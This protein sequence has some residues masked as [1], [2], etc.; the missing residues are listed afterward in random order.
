M[1][2]MAVKKTA[3]PKR[4]KIQGKHV[5]PY[6]FLLPFFVIYI[7][8]NLYPLI[9]T[10]FI[11]LHSWDGFT[12]MSFIGF[13]NY[14]DLFTTDPYF[15]KSIGNTL[16]F[17]AFNIPIS[18]GGG[19][20]LAVML[21]SKLL[22]GSGFFRLASFAP[23]I[24]ISVA[25][26]VLF[27]LLF[28]WNTGMVNRILEA[29]GLIDE[30]I[31]FLGTPALARMVVVLMVCWKYIGYHMIFFN[32]GILGIPMELYEAA[33][34]DGASAWTKFSKITVP[35][36]R[37]ILEFLIIMNIIWGFQFFDEPKVL[38]SPWV[39]ASG[40]AGTAGGP[41]RS[42]LTAVWNIYDTSFGTQMQYGKGAAIAYGLFLFILVFSV[43]GLT[44]MRKGGK[45]DESFKG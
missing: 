28:D 25:I 9:N 13:K 35:M 4:K 18:V 33:D 31:N 20:L 30:K 27:V 3:F 36:L 16:I 5:W 41:L 19:L 23:Y 39:S 29:V 15:W 1:A 37:P 24:T 26:G 45:K 21:N 6:I 44:V 12:D 40:G 42:C 38:F 11:S 34:V 43:F 10:F 8:F 7:A 22:K 2:D 17:M 32:A 14:V